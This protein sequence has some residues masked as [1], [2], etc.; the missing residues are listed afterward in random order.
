MPEQVVPVFKVSEADATLTFWTAL[1]FEVLHDMRRPYIYLSVRRGAAQFD[2][3]NF[4]APAFVLWSVPDVDALN[5]GF[6]AAI[7][8]TYGK[9]LRSGQPRLG[10]VSQQKQDRRF[11]LT[12]PAG[13][14][15]LVLTPGAQSEELP[16]SP[17]SQAI[18]AARLSAYGEGN[19]VWA[20]EHLEKALLAYG[21]QD[22]SRLAALV[23]R[24]DI[25]DL[26]GD[27][28][29]L[30]AAVAMAQTIDLPDAERAAAAFDI[31]RLAVLAELASDQT[32]A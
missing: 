15:V 18:K 27:S 3:S 19:L 12:D 30:R 16:R 17:L 4:V 14:Q 5:A 31:D 28:A 11:N 1:G 20:A 32:P 13:N 22:R 9:Q 25:A 10:L 7:K 26:A 29:G 6:R 21:P 2:F 24:A 23:L 8:A